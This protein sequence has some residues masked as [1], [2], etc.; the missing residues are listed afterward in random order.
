MQ[1]QMTDSPTQA[2]SGEATNSFLKSSVLFSVLALLG[3]IAIAAY[4]YSQGWFKYATGKAS[5]VIVAMSSTAAKPS[6]TEEG[7]S[8]ARAAF[9]SGDVNAAIAGYREVIAKNPE[10]IS[11]QGELGN[12]FY[13]VGMMPD[14]AQAYFATAS[15]AI[16][17]NR[18]EIAE[19]LLPVIIQG[20]PMLA[21]QL[22]D[23]LFEAQMRA[24]LGQQEPEKKS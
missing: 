9:A 6:S 18:P 21:H 24:D 15:M 3:L 23:Q 2:S 12:V 8:Q 22:N 1:A 7:L 17:Q 4:G 13:T 20:D 5:D 10:D 19:S 16:K 14:A 11:A